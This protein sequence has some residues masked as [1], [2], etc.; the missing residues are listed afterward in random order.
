[1]LKKFLFG[2]LAV[3]SSTHVFAVNP[4]DLY[5]APLDSLNQFQV[6]KAKAALAKRAAV[7]A[8]PENNALTQVSQTKEEGMTITRYQQLYKGI[9]VVGAQVMV[10]NGAAQGRSVRADGEVNGHLL[11]DIQIDTNPALSSQQ[12]IDLAK[13]S[14]FSTKP[15]TNIQ[16]QTVELQIRTAANNELQLV[17]LVSFKS[18]DENNKPVWPFFVINAQTG[19]LTAQWNNIKNYLDS[20][21]GGN[22]KVHEYWYGKDGLPSLDV[23]QQGKECVMDNNKVKLVKLNSAWDWYGTMVTPFTYTCNNNTEENINGAYSPANDAYFFGNTIVAMYR[24]WYDVNALQDPQGQPMKLVMRVH[25]GQGYDNAFWDGQSM[26]F[27]DGSFFYP[28]VSLDVAGHE[29]SHG[30]TEQ[31]SSLEY[32]DQSGALNESFSDMAGQTSRAY[33]LEKNPMLFNKSNITPG[34]VTW[35]I[36]ETIMRDGK[37]KALRFMDLPSADGSSADCVDKALAQSTGN[38]CAI[39]YDE[40][41]AFAKENI[42]D[43]QNQQ[44]FIVHTASGVFNKAFYLLSKQIGIKSAYHVML[45]A[46]TKYWTPTTDFD[47]GACGVMHAASELQQDVNT[48]KTV[49]AQVGI[50]TGK[51]VI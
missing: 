50:D 28:L 32:H 43:P 23:V 10:T 20:G 42:P 22:E 13:K 29:V 39:S 6:K 26:S 46:N 3:I 30:Y 38:F 37:E 16:Q 25:F 18:I 51:C 7:A 44:S 5:Q 1:M 31:H 2:S 11:N 45:V 47:S 4:I 9:P 40:L 14:F 19:E 41:A 48:V 34:A 12:A 21:P 8:A 36:G 15:Q 27:G 49:F 17:Y 24:D 35:G 33:L